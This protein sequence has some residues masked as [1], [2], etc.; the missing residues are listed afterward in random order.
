[1]PIMA[2]GM[3]LHDVAWWV[4]VLGEGWPIPYSYKHEGLRV[5]GRGCTCSHTKH[6]MRGFAAGMHA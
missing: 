5:S 1:M 4:G 6:G 3:P 2:Q